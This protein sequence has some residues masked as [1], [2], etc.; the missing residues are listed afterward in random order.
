MSQLRFLLGGLRVTIHIIQSI[1]EDTQNLEIKYDENNPPII[2]FDT[3]VWRS[4]N[5][6]GIATLQR[7]QQRYR[8]RYRYS[9]TNFIELASHL[10]DQPSKCCRDPFRMFQACFRRILKVCDSEILQLGCLKMP[11]RGHL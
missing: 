3:N 2:F 1:V 4:I 7:L 8:F 9:V 6:T 11:C 5:D 10:K